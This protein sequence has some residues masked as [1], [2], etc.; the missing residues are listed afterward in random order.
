MRQAIVVAL[1]AGAVV[2]PACQAPPEPK[3]YAYPAWGFAVSFRAP[4]KETDI[5]ASADGKSAHGFL[6][7]HATDGRDE[8]VNVI[9]G[10]DSTKSEEQALDDA[11]GNLAKY[12]KGTLGPITYAATGKVIGREFLLTRPNKTVA[13]AHVFVFHKRLYEVIATSALGADDPESRRF[14]DSFRL[15]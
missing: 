14:L 3:E 6:V 11:P 5:P 7:E 15:L 9:D 13:I 12:V 1:A 10:S 2:L 4:P 8:L